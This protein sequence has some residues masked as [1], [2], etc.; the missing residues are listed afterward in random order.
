MVGEVVAVRLP[1]TTRI[2]IS[3]EQP[4][5]IIIIAGLIIMIT[6]R[7]SSALAVVAAAVITLLLLEVSTHNSIKIVTNN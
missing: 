7:K 2:A 5:V 3:K 4:S 1:F 6:I